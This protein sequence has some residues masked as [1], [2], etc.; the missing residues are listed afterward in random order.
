MLILDTWDLISAALAVV[1]TI[2]MA[3]ILLIEGTDYIFEEKE[4]K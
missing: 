2:L 3:T 4:E 1:G